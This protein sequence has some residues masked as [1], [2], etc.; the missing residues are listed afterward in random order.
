M[1]DISSIK[2]LTKYKHIAIQCHD[3]PDADAIGAG[4]ALQCWLRSAGADASLVYSGFAEITKPSLL[5]LIDALDIELLYVNELPGDT[6]LLVTVDCQ[7]GAG[8]VRALP[9]PDGADFAVLDHHRPEIPEGEH[10]IIR[11]SLASCST[12]VWDLLV[13]EGFVMDRRIETALF[14]GLY[15]DTNGMAEL[16]HPLDRDMAELAV[17]SGLIRKL[18]DAAI[19][20]E[21][22][23]IIGV[24]LSRREMIDTIGIL[25]ADPCDANLLGF[26]SDIAQQVAQIDCCLVYSRQKFGL[27]LSIRSSVREYMA[28]EFA[29]YLCEETGS[30]GGNYE[31]A[32]GFMGLDKIAEIAPDMTPEDYLTARVRQYLEHYDLIYA[33]NNDV[34]F[35]SMPLYKKLPNPVGYVDCKDVFAAKTKITI[36]TLEGDVDTTTSDDICLMIGIAG[37]VYPIARERLNKSYKLTDEPYRETAEYVPTV[38]NRITGERREILPFARVCIPTDSKLVR[39]RALTRAAKVFTNWDLVKYY[40]GSVGD[41][42]VANND[43][44]DDCYIVRRDIFEITYAEVE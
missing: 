10:C 28:S 20:A 22:L 21:E 32:G 36:R 7:R 5:M 31:K 29:A 44:F 19:T 17:D 2:N 6:D 4:F 39:A 13:K 35:G 15:M 43:D 25:R 11:P 3:V 34:D 24:A 12:L 23:D 27:K 1:V 8:N 38:V 37:E 42:L 9:L 40:H 30:G 33:G 14:Y 16:A 41:F 26:T 18:R